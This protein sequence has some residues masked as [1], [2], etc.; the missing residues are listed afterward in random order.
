MDRAGPGVQPLTHAR[1][2]PFWDTEKRG[3][4]VD[5]KYCNVW[6]LATP[7]EDVPGEWVAHCLS[8]DV[9]SQG[10]SLDEALQA[11]R[12]AIL[13]IVQDDLANNLDPLERRSAPR[14]C[15]EAFTEVMRLGQPVA[16]I[17]DRSK[18]RAL[19]TQY[20]LVRPH[21]PE[22]DG[23]EELPELPPMW[24][25]AALENLRGCSASHA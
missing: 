25:I 22:I 18:I 3:H 1:G 10:S 23:A 5:L 13:M 6:V 14:E 20:Q 9:I 17:P 8:L 12:E 19:V 11:V 15:W 7:A 24:Q 21:H 4:A 16:A 2:A